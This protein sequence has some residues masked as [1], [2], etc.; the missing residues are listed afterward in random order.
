MRVNLTAEFSDIGVLAEALGARLTPIGT[1]RGRIVGVATHAGE[2][3]LGDLFLAMRGKRVSGTAFAGEALARGAGAILA[4]TPF[5][6]PKGSYW[7]LQVPDVGASLLRAAALRRKALSARVIAVAG[8]TGKTTVKELAAAVLSEKY[9]VA[10]SEGNYN[11][12]VGMPLTLL[13]MD[14]C[15]YAVLEIGINGCGEMAPL[16]RVLSPHVALLTNV[17]SAHVGNFP[18]RQALLAEKLAVAEG[19]AEG[20]RLIVPE[21]LPIGKGLAPHVWRLGVGEQADVVATAVRYGPFGTVATVKVGGM[22]LSDLSWPLA[23]RVGLSCLLFAV[24]VGA[25]GGM[26]EAEIRRG[27][28]RAAR[29]TPRMRPIVCGERLLIDDTYNASPEAMLSAL[30]ALSYMGQGRPLAAVLGDM[31]ELGEKSRLYHETVG[32]LAAGGDP[33]GLYFF[34]DAANDYARG[35]G[36]AGLSPERVHIFKRGEAEALVTC[37]VKTLPK[38]ATVLFKASHSVA[39]CEVVKMLVEVLR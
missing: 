20:G 21:F 5:P 16:S 17:G 3:R 24:A 6:P 35:A 14:D 33:A 7:L 29:D 8:S 27:V 31:G 19:L 1:P 34:G 36:Q 28:A 2:C 39:L 30:E 10:K 25:V 9:T 38:N 22:T 18:D 4:D 26:D 15:D 12:G 23:G 32:M 13:S 11:S 37:L